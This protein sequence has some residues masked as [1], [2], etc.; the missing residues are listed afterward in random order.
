MTEGSNP[1]RGFKLMD[2]SAIEK[3]ATLLIEKIFG[4]IE[5]ITKPWHDVLAANA[6]SEIAITKAETKIKID[7]LKH[8]RKSAS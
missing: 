8:R 6:A 4:Q 5:G 2:L 1:A 3:P 7:D